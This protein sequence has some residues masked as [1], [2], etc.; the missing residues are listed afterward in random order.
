M[1][2]RFRVVP[3]AAYRQFQPVVGSGSSSSA[4]T[5]VVGDAD[6]SGGLSGVLAGSA[7]LNGDATTT[8]NVSGDISGNSGIIAVSG[9]VDG[10]PSAL[11]D[12]INDPTNL[13]NLAGLHGWRRQGNRRCNNEWRSDGE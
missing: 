13:G 12:V 8:V 2:E 11:L 1:A 10:D 6:V 9:S 3:E 5:F 7:S 4:Q